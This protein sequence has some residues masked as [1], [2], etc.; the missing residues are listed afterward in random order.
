VYWASVRIGAFDLKNLPYAQVKARWETA[1]EEQM[2]SSAW[3][4]VPQPAPALP[5]PGKSEASRVLAQQMMLQLQANGVIQTMF[6][7]GDH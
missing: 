2:R 6:S 5:A 7:R 3:P 1:L 4:T